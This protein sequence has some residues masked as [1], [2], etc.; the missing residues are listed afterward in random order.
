MAVTIKAWN[1][2]RAGYR[3]APKFYSYEFRKESF[4]TIS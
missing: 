3:K 1:H 4:P 2:L